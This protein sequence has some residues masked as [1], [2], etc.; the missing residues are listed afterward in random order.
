MK[1]KFMMVTLLLAGLTMGACVDDKESA[2][3]TAVRDAKT[4]QLE[5][6]AAMNSAA[7]EAKQAI[8]AAEAALKLAKAQAEQAAADLKNADAELQKKKNELIELQKE[9]QTIVNQQKQ[10]QLQAQLAQLEV[11]KKRAEQQLAQIQADMEKAR[12]EAEKNLINSEIAMKKAEQQLLN[13]EKQLADAKTEAERAR[14]EAEREELKNLSLTYST[15]VENLNSAK[16]NLLLWQ[17]YLVR[18]ENNLVNEKEAKELAIAANNNEIARLEMEIETLKQY[19]NYIEDYDSLQAKWNDVY[20]NYTAA[21]DVFYAANKTF[22]DYTPDLSASDEAKESIFNDVLFNFVYNYALVDENGEVYKYS[23]GSTYYPWHYINGRSIDFEVDY[24]P[25]RIFGISPILYEFKDGDYVVTKQF[26]DSLYME[27]EAMGDLR[28]FEL[29]AEDGINYY[30]EILKDISDEVAKL[31]RCYNGKPTMFEA[32]NEYEKNADGT[33]KV[34]T[35]GNPIPSTAIATNYV[36]STLNAKKAY[37]EAADA[38]KTARWNEYTAAL[39]RE[40]Q[41]KRDLEAAIPEQADA[42]LNL[43]CFKKEIDLVRNFADYNAKLQAKFKAFNEQQVKDHAEQVALWQDLEAK[44]LAYDIAV[45]EASAVYGILYYAD[46]EYSAFDINYEIVRRE[47]KIAQLKEAN[48]D[49]SSIEELEELIPY[50]K[51]MITVREDYVKVYEIQAAQ[52]KA[53]LE[54]AMAKYATAEE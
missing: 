30:T 6:V 11:T 33:V 4:E 53:D 50:I 26:G 42:Q 7:A 8:A 43:D 29:D 14:I 45:T 15:A 2:S 27:F 35:D 23:D 44:R 10:A 54:A 21:H 41:C 25:D 39:G 47:N 17:S 13:Y 5:S 38:D 16:A 37:D 18:I 49:M 40:Q 22:V 24:I 46:N 52:A 12:V 31:Q 48:A 20:L 9:E 3:V 19:T 1:K 34:D 28:Q 51:D 32:Y 36:D